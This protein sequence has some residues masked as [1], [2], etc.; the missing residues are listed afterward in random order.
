MW[1]RA[2]P[3]C[4]A[5]VPRSLVLTRGDDLICPSCHTVLELS[6]PSRILAAVVGLLVALLA[7]PCLFGGSQALPWVMPIL[8][9]VLGYGAASALVLFYLADLVVQPKPPVT[10]HIHPKK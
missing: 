3:L 9:A 4:F 6:R 8:G 10:Q 5:K 7:A 2:C 1:N